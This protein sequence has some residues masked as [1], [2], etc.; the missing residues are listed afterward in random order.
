MSPWS[1]SRVTG[2]CLRWCV[3]IQL[4]YLI[5]IPPANRARRRCIR[6]EMRMKCDTP[7]IAIKMATNGHRRGRNR[8]I[9]RVTSNTPKSCRKTSSRFW[10]AQGEDRP[11]RCMK[12]KKRVAAK[13]H[14][15][16]LYANGSAYVHVE[17]KIPVETWWV[18]TINCAIKLRPPSSTRLMNLGHSHRQKRSRQ[19]KW[20]IQVAKPIYRPYPVSN[21]HFTFFHS[22]H[23]CPSTRESYSM[24]ILF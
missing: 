10:C 14:V 18:S 21:L 5:R 12:E 11:A 17:K 20:I 15:L 7:L 13:F 23:S 24:I 9:K 8:Q 1:I 4:V 22:C 3:R 16:H 2:E 19:I 6:N